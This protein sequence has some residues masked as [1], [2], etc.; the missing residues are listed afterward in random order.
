METSTGTYI[1][2]RRKKDKYKNKLKYNFVKLTR[3]I[4]ENPQS[5]TNPNNNTYTPQTILARGEGIGSVA[6]I[7]TS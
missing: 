1:R 2:I 6:L 4:K 3:R 5:H 7:I